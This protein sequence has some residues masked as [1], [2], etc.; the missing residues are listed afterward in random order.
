MDET[1][2]ALENKEKNKKIF[3]MNCTIQSH[4]SYNIEK[5]DKYDISI[6]SSK[7]DEDLSNTIL[8]YAQGA[9]DA[10]KQLRKNV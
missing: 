3:Y 5:Y 9:Y 2:K 10:D 8:S 6:S 4:Q 7:L 1:I